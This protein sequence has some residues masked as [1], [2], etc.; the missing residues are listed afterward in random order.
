MSCLKCRLLGLGAQKSNIAIAQYSI[1][2]TILP[3]KKQILQS[4]LTRSQMMELVREAQYPKNH[5][6]SSLIF[7]LNPNAQA[8]MALTCNTPTSTK[9]VGLQVMCHHT[10][11]RPSVYK[12]VT[13]TLKTQRRNSRLQ[14]VLGSKLTHEDQRG[15]TKLSTL[16]DTIMS[17]PNTASPE[18]Y[19]QT[20]LRRKLHDIFQTFPSTSVELHHPPSRAC[21]QATPAEPSM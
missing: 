11:A 14:Q 16:Y 2:F 10:L 5:N 1:Q 17:T 4:L 12:D 20:C 13:F 7:F 3:Q 9:L 6:G 15:S 8:E 21:N 19:L 18:N